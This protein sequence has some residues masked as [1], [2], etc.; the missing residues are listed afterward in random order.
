MAR[1]FVRPE[2]SNLFLKELLGKRQILINP[3]WPEIK[4][5][6][7]LAQKACRRNTLTESEVRQAWTEFQDD[8]LEL[9]QAGG[10]KC[11]VNYGY[12][13]EGTIFQAVKITPQLTGV[14]IGRERA[15][16]GE[17]GA[18]PVST[19]RESPVAWRNQVITAFWTHLTDEDIESIYRDTVAVL[20]TAEDAFIRTKRPNDQGYRERIRKRRALQLQQ[21]FQGTEPRFISE[22][23]LALKSIAAELEGTGQAQIPWGQFKKRWPSLA[24]RYQRDL[25][26]LLQQS[27]ITLEAIQ[28]YIDHNTTFDLSLDVWTGPQRTFLQPQIV[29]RIMAPA[30]LKTLSQQSKGHE[31]LIARLMAMAKET[32]HPTN[33]HTIGWLRVHVDEPNRLIFIDEV[34]SDFME[35]AW[36]EAKERQSEAAADM[37]K[38]L[39]D[40]LF[41]GFAT[42]Q[43]WSHSIGYRVSMHSK[44]SAAKKA[45]K[46]MTPSERKW[47]IYYQALIN[48]YGLTERRVKGYP[49]CICV[50][51][52]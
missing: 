20:M 52:G 21:L 16:P 47:N 37:T 30:A 46:G 29:F 1:D 50:E 7:V 31:Q 15:S 23:S 38:A 19:D 13:M 14:L 2:I 26:G 24:S 32:I 45:K 43:H 51:A 10:F 49:A 9:G 41:H 25:L 28:H 35:W 3:D 22:F 5:A 36:A 39:Q 40:W 4:H 34:Q 12:D 18:F 33:Q 44:A 17:S 6:L 48:R 42:V 11:P 27:R 8:N